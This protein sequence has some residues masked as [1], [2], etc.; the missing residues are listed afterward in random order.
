MNNFLFS[1]KRLTRFFYTLIFLYLS[2]YIQSYIFARFSTD[3]LHIDLV[4]ILLIF[5]CMERNIFS[6]LFFGL[7]AGILMHVFSS[8][9]PGIFIIYYLFCSILSNIISIV[10]LLNS[11]FFKFFIFCFLYLFKY[12]VLYLSLGNKNSIDFLLF[13]IFS[14]KSICITITIGLI[15]FQVLHH[16]ENKLG[17]I[18]YNKKTR[19][20]KYA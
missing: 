11:M 16:F 14:W 1:R 4:T 15:L 9:P 20:G 17:R 19:L 10:F 13:L 6:S 8:A 5:I 3:W 7:I 2:V 18:T 12:F